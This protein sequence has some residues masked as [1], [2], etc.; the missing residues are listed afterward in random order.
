M[1]SIDNKTMNSLK[2]EF[3]AFINH[4]FSEGYKAGYKDAQPPEINF[5]K[6]GKGDDGEC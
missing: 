3:E 4:I 1:F 2:I 5:R 6:R